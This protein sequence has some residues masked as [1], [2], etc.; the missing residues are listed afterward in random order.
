M[1]S[2]FSW[3]QRIYRWRPFFRPRSVV[4]L[5][6][7][8]GT[9][10]PCHKTPTFDK[11]LADPAAYDSITELLNNK[12]SGMISTSRYTRTVPCLSWPRQSRK[13]TGTTIR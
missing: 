3:P 2:V 11:K 7:P 13:A 4:P 10:T 8:V 5:A 12:S 6:A 9:T 1:H